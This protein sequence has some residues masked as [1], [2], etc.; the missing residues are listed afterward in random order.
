M[1]ERTN[2]LLATSSFDRIP[3]SA[4]LGVN[5]A[6]G[7]SVTSISQSVQP[8]NSF[9]V[10]TLG[11]NLI[12]GA[13]NRVSVSSIYFPY[14]IPTI[15]A[16]KNDRFAIRIT[17]FNNLTVNE[18]IDT[19]VIIPQGFYTGSELANALDTAIVS[20]GSTMVPP[21]PAGTI[22]ASWDNVNG[23]I[24]LENTDT[25][26]PLGTNWVA[27]IF[28]ITDSSGFLNA[29]APN[30][31]SAPNL[32]WTMGFRNYFANHPAGRRGAGLATASGTAL[33]PY[34]FPVG[35]LPASQQP[36]Y[37]VT[38]LAG[39]MYTG[40]YTSFIDI[41]SPSLCRAQFVR[42]GT[43]AQGPTRRDII[44]RLFVTNDVNLYQTDPTGTRPFV[45]NR[46]FPNGTQKIMNWTVNTSI[47]AIDLELYDQ[48]G[49]QLPNV[50]NIAQSLTVLIPGVPLLQAGSGQ[51]DYSITFHVH[52][53]DTLVLPND[54]YRY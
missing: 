10:Q 8:T 24:V 47:E 14:A 44:C 29:Y 35:S 21:L 3:A 13:I 50:S 5:F 7:S 33:I 48:Y 32:L 26:D 38:L 12:Q 30:A 41:V 49:Q 19:N 9:R 34:N 37:A 2:A 15:I 11:A 43:T 52:E 1:A 22:V 27:E 17:N 42:D 51:P 28:A 23:C 54:G 46:Q 4:V 39:A 16:G 40:V 6:P 18:Q 25:Y 20:A 45:I 31:F 36:L 53:H